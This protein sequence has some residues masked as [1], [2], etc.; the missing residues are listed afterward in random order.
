MADPDPGEMSREYDFS[1]MAGV[2]R[3]KY[4]SRSTVKPR[5]V[6]FADDFASAFQNDE[7]VNAALRDYLNRHTLESTDG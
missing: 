1:T 2:V 7:A 6:R 4:S 3:G 5:I